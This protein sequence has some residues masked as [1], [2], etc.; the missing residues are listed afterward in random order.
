MVCFI[1]GLYRCSNRIFIMSEGHQDRTHKHSHERLY[2][3][4]MLMLWIFTVLLC[5]RFEGSTF[6]YPHQQSKFWSRFR[7][8]GCNYW[9][10]CHLIICWGWSF[11]RRIESRLKWLWML[12]FS[13][14][15]WCFNLTFGCFCYYEC[16]KII[17][18]SSC[19][20]FE[21]IINLNNDL[22]INSRNLM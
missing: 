17:G 3:N 2:N 18:F 13:W 7:L 22:L 10:I 9:R 8:L 1:K 6:W 20:F 5:P 14:F 19:V 12:W 16:S 21:K 4:L 11:Y 15:E